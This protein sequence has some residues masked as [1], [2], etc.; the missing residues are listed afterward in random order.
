MRVSKFLGV[1]AGL[2]LFCAAIFLM[3]RS[4]GGFK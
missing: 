4:D 3:A 2:A 1:L